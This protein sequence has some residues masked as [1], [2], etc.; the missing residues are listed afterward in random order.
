MADL[1]VNQASSDELAIVYRGKVKRFR[2][3]RNGYEGEDFFPGLGENGKWLCF[4]AVQLT[5]ADG[6]IQGAIETLQ[7]ITDKRQ[8]EQELRASEARY[9]QLFESANDAIFLLKNGLIADCNLKT[10]DL[11]G[12]SREA[13]TGLSPLDLSPQNQAGGRSSEDEVDRKLELLQRDIPQFFEWRFLRKDGSRFDAEVSLNRFI[14]DGSSYA[15]AVIRDISLR[16][17]M[18]RTLEEHQLALDEKSTY[19]EKVNQALKASLDH[20]EVEKR[21]VEENML[22]NL[23]RFV[24][25]YLGELETCKLGSEAQAYLNIVQ[26]HLNDIVSQFSRTIFSKYIDLTPTEVRIADFIRDG[27]NSKEIANMLALSPSSIQWHRKNIRQ[28]LGL[29][30]KKVNLQTYLNSLSE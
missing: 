22:V 28:K 30:N 21:A 3:T 10:L 5:D 15:L 27:K 17:Q 26:T 23:K 12:R 2:H 8:A 29:T 20:R 24:F 9:R 7:D 25:P 13:M 19:L 16:K 4:T 14:I 11:F 6:N 18:I 1:I